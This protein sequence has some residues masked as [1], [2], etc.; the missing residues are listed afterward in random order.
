MFFASDNL[1][2]LTLLSSESRSCLDYSLGS[3]CF[4]LSN[5]I[6][7]YLVL[8]GR[9]SAIRIIPIPQPAAENHIAPIGLSGYLLAMVYT[10]I[11]STAV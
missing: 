3:I 11:E 2:M 6:L 5:S 4:Y 7:S 8:S 9:A 10:T 1:P